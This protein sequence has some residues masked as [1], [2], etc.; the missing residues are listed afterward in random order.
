[1]Y[2]PLKGSNLLFSSLFD[3]FSSSPLHCPFSSSAEFEYCHLDHHNTFE[4]RG[5]SLAGIP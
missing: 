4:P 3:D 1:M 2:L 5:K